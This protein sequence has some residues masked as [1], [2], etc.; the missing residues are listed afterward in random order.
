MKDPLKVGLAMK[1]PAKQKLEQ[2]VTSDEKIM[3]DM[4]KIEANAALLHIT[5][6]EKDE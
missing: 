4:A 5:Q 1:T 3:M 6:S 2:L